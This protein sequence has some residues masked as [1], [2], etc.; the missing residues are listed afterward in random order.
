V[1]TIGG[2]PQ[3]VTIT[4]QGSDDPALVS[5]DTHG[6]V[7][8]AG[9]VHNATHGVPTAIGLLTD[10]DVDDPSTTFMAVT[11]P[12]RSDHGYGSFT[13]TADGHW[14]YALDD[15]N[16]AVQALNVS[17]T[18]TDTFVVKTV[19]G[20]AQTVTITIEGSNDA[21]VICGDTHGCVVEPSSSCDPPSSAKGTLTDRDVDNPDN[22]FA[23]VTCPRMSDHGYGSFTLTACGTWTYTLDEDNPAVKTLNACDTLTD[24]FTVTTIDGTAQTVAVTIQGADD[25][26]LH[27]F[28]G[29][30][31]SSSFRFK[32]DTA[33]QHSSVSAA[34]ADPSAA[35]GPHDSWHGS[36]SEGGGPHPADE[37]PDAFHFAGHGDFADGRAAI[38]LAFHASHHDLI[39]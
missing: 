33:P 13:M 30:A 15:G 20:T 25:V 1:T 19:D 39:A 21:A 10:T 35:A 12:Q 23:A 11:C 31:N 8:E 18:L 27:D 28:H 17:Q 37:A 14:T 16:C 7:V 26:G 22:T 32:D 9:G 6:C 24:T 5:G 3:V 29:Q 2:T 38:G 34:S 36:S 4:I